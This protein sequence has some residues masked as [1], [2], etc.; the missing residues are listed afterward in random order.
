MKRKPIHVI[1][2][3]IAFLSG[4]LNTLPVTVCAVAVAVLPFALSDDTLARGLITYVI[5]M[6]SGGLFIL[7]LRRRARRALADALIEEA[8]AKAEADYNSA[9]LAAQSS[10][11]FIIRMSQLYVEGAKQ[12]YE[13]HRQEQADL[14]RM[15][16][17]VMDVIGPVNSRDEL[18]MERLYRIQRVVDGKEKGVIPPADWAEMTGGKPLPEHLR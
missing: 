4:V 7:H 9:K 3:D 5:G 6:A 2:N 1:E 14:D 13:T 17:E 12:R 11:D 10:T 15:R 8:S 18:I 16:R